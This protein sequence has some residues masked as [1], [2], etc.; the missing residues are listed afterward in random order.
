MS[1]MASDSDRLQ[2]W[3]RFVRDTLGCGCPDEVLSKIECRQGLAGPSYP[4]NRLDVGGRLLVLIVCD[5]QSGS[6]RKIVRELVNLGLEE[7]DRLAFN[8]LRLVLASTNPGAISGAA[9]AAFAAC[10]LPDDRVHL[11]TLSSGE[12]PVR[13][14]Q[15]AGMR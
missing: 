4:Y 3:Q 6:V 10:N 11:H 1:N 15:D 8:R 7:R 5:P 9:E 14:R 2:S 13:L 12:L